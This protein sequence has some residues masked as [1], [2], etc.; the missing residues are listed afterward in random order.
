[1]AAVAVLWSE[2]SK[3]TRRWTLMIERVID[4]WDV[5]REYDLG[6]GA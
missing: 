5:D 1:M 3:V 4:N 6:R 2:L